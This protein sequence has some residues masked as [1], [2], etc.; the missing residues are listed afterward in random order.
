MSRKA[1]ELLSGDGQNGLAVGGRSS[2]QVL[3][4]LLGP[5]CPAIVS[6]EQD[7][8]VVRMRKGETNFLPTD[9]VFPQGSDVT[10]PLTSFPTPTLKSG[11]QFVAQAGFEITIPL[12]QPLE[13]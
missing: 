7:C 11:I 13:C 4:A 12:P 8:P 10:H 9:P 3:D 2:H 6:S 1:F 5:R